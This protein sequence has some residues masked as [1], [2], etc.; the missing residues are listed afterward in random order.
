MAEKYRIIWSQT[1][2]QDL[3][4]LIEYITRQG[5]VLNAR[6]VYHSLMKKIEGLRRY[7]LRCRVIPE[8]REIGVLEFRE[9]IAK[10]YRIFFRLHR[11]HVV[12]VGVL[13]GRRDLQE[14][15][16]QRAI[17]LG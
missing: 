17:A 16:I 8:M 3:D 13:D 15:L 9:V 10:P 11:R 2:V 6:K 1:A 4:S 7:P 5:D 12:L 14:V